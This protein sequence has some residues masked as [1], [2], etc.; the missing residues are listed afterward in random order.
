VPRITLLP[1]WGWLKV[2][3]SSHVTTGDV[4]VSVLLQKLLESGPPTADSFAPRCSE[5]AA[6]LIPYVIRIRTENSTWAAETSMSALEMLMKAKGP[7]DFHRRWVRTEAQRI[8]FSH[9]PLAKPL[10]KDTLEESWKSNREMLLQ[11]F[12]IETEE[13]L[14]QMEQSLLALET[15]T[16]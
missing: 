12:R 7:R 5:A 8:V 6:C 10:A 15:Q 4:A 9:R 13:C 2:C 1:T 14:A 11:S 16:R 3:R